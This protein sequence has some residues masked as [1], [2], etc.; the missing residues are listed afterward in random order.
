MPRLLPNCS[1]APP[2]T[3]ISPF[4]PPRKRAVNHWIPDVPLGADREMYRRS[5]LHLRGITT[6]ARL[7]D[8]PQ[9]ARAERA[10]GTT[11]TTTR[12]SP[13]DA[14]TP[15]R[16]HQHRVARDQDAPLQRTRGSTATDRAPST[17]RN[18]SPRATSSRFSATRLP[19]S[20]AS[21]PPTQPSTT[22]TPPTLARRSSATDLSWLPSSS[23][24][25]VF[26][27]PPFGANLFYGDCNVVWEAWLGDVTDPTEE[28]V[29]NRSLPVAAG[30]KTIT[31]YEK[32]L[33]DAFTEVHR[34]LEPGG[35]RQRR[36]P[37]LRRQGVVRP[38]RRHRPRRPRANRRQRP[39]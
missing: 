11:S 37:Q 14:R 25:Y 7:L 5:A 30:G 9:Q 23:I 1:A 19:R 26:T 28:I 38:P 17:S 33:G 31:D 16:L 29:V 18:S 22:T 39:R 10:A 21:T 24:D 15:V 12:R 32:L 8:P 2:T 20:A 34:V 35:T 36:L 6:V 3:P 13:P 27:D 4:S